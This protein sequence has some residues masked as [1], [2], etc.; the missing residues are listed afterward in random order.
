MRGTYSAAVI[1]TNL[2]GLSDFGTLTIELVP[3]PASLLLSLLAA[4]L[5]CRRLSQ[6]N[7]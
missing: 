3:E 6:L 4:A 5:L 2:G 1:V 7:R